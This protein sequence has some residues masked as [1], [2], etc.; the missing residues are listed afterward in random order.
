[1]KFQRTS[2]G[3]TIELDDEEC[4]DLKS[5]L[6]NYLLLYEHPLNATKAI[7]SELDEMITEEGH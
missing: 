2:K 4:A 7:H 3:V 6:E 1:M 5:D